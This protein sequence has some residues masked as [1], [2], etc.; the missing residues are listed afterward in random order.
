MKTWSLREPPHAAPPAPPDS[1]A[2]ELS[3]SPLLLHI[4]WKRGLLERAD[5]DAFLTARLN[6]LT[7]PDKWPQLPQAAE[8]LAAELLAGKKLAVWGDYDVDGIT[9]ATLVLDV[10]ETHGVSAEW[11]IPDRRSE[12]YGLNVPQVEALAARGCD[13]LLTVDCGISDAQAVRRA[14][15]LGM[16]VVVSDH[17]LPPE[18]LPPAHAICNP[19]VCRAEELPYPHLAGVG[20]AF[21]LM[22]AVNAALAAHTNKRHAMGDCLDLVA[23]GTLA[24]VMPLTGEN[25][26]LVRGG[27]T[28][29]ARAARPGMAALKVASGINAAAA[30]SAGQAVFRLAPRIN[31]AGR[32]GKGELALRL[33]REKDHAAAAA[34]AQELDELN[35][36]RRQEEERIYA[37]A[38]EQAV[39]MLSR[40]PRAS[41]V[42]Y[43]KSW[44]PGIVGIV[45]SRIV[46]DFYRPTIILCE[47][48]GSLK[49]SGRSVHE[50]DL[51]DGLSRTAECLLSFG[52]H[53]QAAGVRLAPERL[54]E[55]RARFEAAAEEALGPTP[56][57]PSITLECELGFDQAGDVKFL[58]E[59]EMLQPFGP[60]NPEPVFQSPPLLVKERSFIGRGREHVLLR[61][62]DEA[63]G[64][65]LPAK[66]WRMAG[67][68]PPTLVNRHIRVA[69][70]PRID[71]FNGV[72]SVDIAIK[73]WRPA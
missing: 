8:L 30:L 40:G 12:G 9:A 57:V 23:L 6:S 33:L 64:I 63:S 42:L 34:M 41:L 69:Y 51:H 50:F 72:A 47:D 35:L 10:L 71:T 13:I 52:G 26:V 62:R 36:A 20:V 7:P 37:E 27:L 31:A 65:T 21:Y 28:R 24:D 66:A 4:L 5:M 44:H 67:Q 2:E 39:D 61:L 16:T 59:L 38:R 43:G 11:H 1:W 29:L 22:G 17:H 70:T 14:R 53:R 55:F 19:R 25:R 18:E 58:K 60:G 49:G 68:L 15:E 73:D 48:Q 45:A 32:M 3:I 46:E 56:L 54:E